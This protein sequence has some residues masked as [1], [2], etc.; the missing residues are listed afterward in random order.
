[1]KKMFLI[2]LLFVVGC[3]G[4]DQITAETPFGAV[5]PNDVAAVGV[6][7][8]ATGT[9]MTTVGTVTG[10]PT[11]TGIGILF[12]GAAVVLNMVA[13]MLGKKRR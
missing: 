5:E 1:M 7:V 9:A 6:A 4:L 10:Q 2:G 3:G 12:V 13:E 11:V 8:E